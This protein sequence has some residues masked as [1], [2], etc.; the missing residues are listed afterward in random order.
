MGFS[1]WSL[2]KAALLCTNALAIL[3]EPRFLTYCAYL[4]GGR[5]SCVSAT[6]AARSALRP[7]NLSAVGAHVT[8]P[9][10]SLPAARAC[11]H[12][13]FHSP[14]P[15]RCGD[16]TCART[17]TTG[18]VANKGPAEGSIGLDSPSGMK[19]QVANF[20]AAV[21]YLRMPL[22]VMNLLAIVVEILIG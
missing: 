20:L 19:L 14:C 11:A 5:R 15:T 10:A 13:R 8:L 18:G 2:V 9:S 6:R 4:R 1:L 21:R 22:M 3:N 17:H 16:P 12:Y 7:R